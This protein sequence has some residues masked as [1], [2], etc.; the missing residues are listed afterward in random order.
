[1]FGYLRRRK[2]GNKRIGQL[3]LAVVLFTFGGWEF[4]SNSIYHVAQMP[5]IFI[6]LIAIQRRADAV[7]EQPVWQNGSLAAPA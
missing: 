2:V 1:M 7:G 6:M 3:P 5:G 4:D